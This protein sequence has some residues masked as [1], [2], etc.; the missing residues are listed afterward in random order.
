M[1]LQLFLGSAGS[2]KSY[3]LYKEVI[4]ESKKNPDTN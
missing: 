1:S 2:G 4:E 3:Q